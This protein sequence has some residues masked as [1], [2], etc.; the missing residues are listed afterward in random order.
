MAKY[1]IG[2]DARM[3]DHP[4][5]GRYIRE[6]AGQFVASTFEHKLVFLGNAGFREKF[7]SPLMGRDLRCSFREANSKIYSISEQFEIFNKSKDLDL[8]HVPHFNIPV[9]IKKKLV[10][11]IHDLI[12]LH[13]PAASKS[14]FGKTYVSWLLKAIE[15]KA[16]AI[17]AVSEYT[18]KDILS[19]C[20]KF[21][22]TRI[23]V[24][25]EAVSPHFKKI[26]DAGV[27][28]GV[29]EKH[30][31]YKPFVLYVGSLKAHKNIPTLIEA[32]NRLRQHKGIDHELILV[33]RKDPKNR[34][35]LELIGRDPFVRYLGELDDREIVSLYNLADLFVLPSFREG[36]GLPVLEAMT[37]GAPV[38]AS[39]ACSLP[40][41]VGGA[42]LLFDPGQVD[43]LS[44]LIYNVLSDNNLRENMRQMGFGQVKKFSW[45]KTAQDTL[46]VYRQVLA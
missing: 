28:N 5:I 33:G 36:F 13:D 40:E 27:L 14:V 10:V 31:L 8:L 17:I 26:Q 42:G 1:K 39:N 2:I 22:P 37:C 45:E 20:P 4:G 11:T 46:K 6:L 9:F 35:L 18:K 19:H 16:A 38:I 15:R 23:F 24:T 44:G 30:S 12:Y 43:A 25:Y 34:D 32:M 7:F 41:V 29:K 21:D 3:W